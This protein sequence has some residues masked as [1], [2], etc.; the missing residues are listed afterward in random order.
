MYV[1]MLR[2]F[3]SISM[4]LTGKGR[5]PAKQID[6]TEENEDEMRNCVTINTRV[7]IVIACYSYAIIIF[8]LLD[9]T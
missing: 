7:T 9:F 8:H 3:C 1:L 4:L 2:N 6:S 5:N